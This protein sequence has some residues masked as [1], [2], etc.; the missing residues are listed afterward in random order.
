[1]IVDPWG[2]IVNQL[3]DESEG[4]LITTL[5]KSLITDIRQKMPVLVRTAPLKYFKSI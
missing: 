4:Y 1:M 3:H 2:V 5:R